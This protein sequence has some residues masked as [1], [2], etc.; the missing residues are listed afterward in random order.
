MKQT[1][2]GKPACQTVRKSKSFKYPY[3]LCLF[4]IFTL[5]VEVVESII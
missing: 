3:I 5:T 1:K 2:K 4:S